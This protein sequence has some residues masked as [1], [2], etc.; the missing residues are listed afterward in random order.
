MT[1]SKTLF[2][3]AVLASATFSGAAM[4]GA[5]CDNLPKAAE[6]KKVLASIATGD[7]MANGGVGAPEWLT[8][9]DT[10]GT[11]CAVVHSLPADADVTT[12]A[13]PVHRIFSAQKAGTANGFSRAGIAVSTSNLYLG[14]QVMGGEIS[15]GMD[16]FLNP[17]INPN[18]GS[19][20][21]W[22]TT[23]DPLIG[24][25]LG[26]NNTMPG[27]LPLYDKTHTKVGAIGVSG[28]IRCSDHVVA[29]KVREALSGGAYTVAN[30]AYG[31]SS[32]HNDAMMQ[33]VG[34]DGKSKSGFGYPACIINN[35]TD[36][37][38]G[39]SIEGN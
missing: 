38:D 24:K 26:G 7:P 4:A 19:T 12:Q 36:A 39:G 11:I 35:P 32:A 3:S 25:R 28:D 18:D 10:S 33:D 21:N 9:V 16:A 6:L 27:G 15:S 17:N 1:I 29:W 34:A 23:K 20:K 22:G 31:L 5:T 14:T 8:L 13:A 30:N 2:A 37:N